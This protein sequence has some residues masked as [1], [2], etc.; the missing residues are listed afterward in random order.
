MG[1]STPLHP[2]RLVSAS[3]SSR[4]L[5]VAVPTSFPDVILAAGQFLLR[6][7]LELTRRTLGRI[8]VLERLGP[9]R[10]NKWRNDSRQ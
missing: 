9:A 10:V 6:V 3:K 8:I 5:C 2:D 4:L 7:L 1:E